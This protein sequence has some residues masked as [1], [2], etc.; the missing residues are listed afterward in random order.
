MLRTETPVEI[1]LKDYT[2]PAFRIEHTDLEVDI[3]EHAT[4]VRATLRMERQ[5]DAEAPLELDGEKLRLLSV[6]IDGKTL[7]EDAYT[8][9]EHSL[10]IPS[11]PDSFVLST[12]VEIDP[13]G[14]TALMGLYKSGS[15]YCTQ[16]EAEGFR[17]I[18][19][20]L[21][22]PDTMS[23]FRTKIIADKT[24]CPVLLSNGNPVEQGDLEGGRHFV[25]WEDP[26]KKPAYL[27][28]LV[29]GDLGEARDSFTTVSGRTIDL[30]I[31]TEHGKEDRVAYA[32]DSL[33]RSMAWDEK[34]FG[35][36]Y[37]LDIFMIVAVSD[38]NFGAMENKGLN[39]FNDALLL[40]S[41]ETATDLDYQRIEAVVAHEYFH[42]W[43]G[44]RVTCRDW[45]QLCL[46]EGLTV[47]RDQEFSSDERERAVKRIEDVQMLRARQFPED[48]GALAHPVRPESFIK[49]DNFYTATV[50]E[51]GAEVIRMLKTLLGPDDFRK[52]MALYFERCD[53]TAAT[54]EDFYAAFE[55]ASGKDL[56]HFRKWYSQAGTPRVTA[57]GDYDAAAKTFTLTLSQETA[58]TPGQPKKEALVIPVAMG[59]ITEGGREL[60]LHLEGDNETF[61][62]TTRV[63]ELR[64]PSQTFVFHDV[65]ERPVPSLLRGFSAPVLLK[66]D[67]SEQDLITLMGKDADP[68]NRWEAGRTIATNLLT[69]AASGETRSTEGFVEGLRATLTDPSLDPAFK[70]RALD[71]PDAGELAQAMDVVDPDAIFRA[72]TMLLKAVAAGLKDEL[73]ALHKEMTNEGPFSPEAEAAGRRALRNA[74]L[75]KLGA[76]E[77]PEIIAKAKDQA[78][79]AD[80]MTDRMAGLRVLNHIACPERE[81][82]LAAFYD[83]WKDDALVVNKWLMLQAVSE[84]PDTLERVKALTEHE[85]F[86][87]R[88]PNKVRSLI[89]VFAMANQVRFH[90]A[91]GEGY[92]FF[93]DT[94]LELDKLNPMVAA[95]LFG[96]LESWRKFTPDRREAMRATL[97]RVRDTKGI[98]SNLYEIASRT[99]GSEAEQAR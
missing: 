64:A 63:L 16:C 62:G 23:L 20:F 83:Q 2:P 53:G 10:S 51:K 77:T 99:L 34:V 3:A 47:F 5:G 76:L 68:F 65:D 72:R 6:A 87:L 36:E 98:S 7:S 52:G 60:P 24:A 97:T 12:E 22:R 95:R 48:A 18:T 43:S 84:L 4:V 69:S 92:R 81:E 25:T 45:F 94:L 80:N 88:N 50:Y 73:E 58:P 93:A 89:G 85:A 32:M 11:V 90:D 78:L 44:N 70:A 27:F 59:L 67:L 57:K 40:A 75:G 33:K 54:V 28:A 91:S 38:F 56:A 19:Y 8:A 26:F 21:D 74:A 29:A 55:T 15:M 35:L 42:N 66:S 13:A 79:S 46:K 39:I 41:P 1:H 14:N 61:E 96:A 82:A 37:D 17:R 71:L 49:I 86:S 30:R 31:Y 9:D